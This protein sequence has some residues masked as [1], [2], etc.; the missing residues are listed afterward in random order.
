MNVQGINVGKI[1]DIMH[2]CSE[3]G[4]DVVC[5]TETQLIE[6]VEID[7]ADHAY[8][9]IGKGRSKQLR[10]GGGVAVMW[11]KDA[12]IECEVL[13]VGNCEM[14]E[15]ILAMKLECL[16]NKS[17]KEA[18]FVCV[19]YVTVE[20]VLGK[21]EN[22]KKY[23]LLRNFM[24]KYGHERIIIMG[25]MNAH[26][27]VLGESQNNNGDLLRE[28]C[29]SMSLEILNETIAE[30]RVTWNGRECKSAI[31][32]VL[33]NESARKN[34]IDMRIDEEG[35][36]D[37]NSDHN[38]MQVRYKCGIYDERH[39]KG[40]KRPKWK[41]KDA[42]WDIFR[43][44]MNEVMIMD[45]DN[46]EQINENIVNAVKSVA[47]G[48]IGQS[49]GVVRCKRRNVWW[50]QEIKE[51]RKMRKRLNKE[52]RKLRKRRESGEVVSDEVYNDAWNSYKVQQKKV[53]SMIKHA[54]GIKE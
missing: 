6:S 11:R 32:Y 48:C 23:E 4:L 14:S 27:G 20:G 36:F 18:V 33:T 37:S 40:K 44:G 49:K 21:E 42:N 24:D 8:H 54:R 10:K 51:E 39:K 1:D 35:E 16:G 30:G 3:W 47:R 26:I 50:S 15:D 41:L 43:E 7:D 28:A 53:K 13:D 9:F 38:L 31:D 25:D 34:I 2:E 12:K 17:K 5:L 52:C 29:E 19:C 22:Q 45:D 46:A